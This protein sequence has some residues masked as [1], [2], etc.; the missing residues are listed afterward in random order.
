[1]EKMKREK[2]ILELVGKETRSKK[3][4]GRRKWQRPREI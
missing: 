3:Y 1:V 4:N 2:G